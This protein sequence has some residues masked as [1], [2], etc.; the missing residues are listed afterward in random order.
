MAEV[1]RTIE[2][3]LSPH[4]S[5]Y[6]MQINMA[7]SIVH[8]VTGAALYFGTLLLAAWL[9]SAA[10]GAEAFGFVNQLL[11]HPLGLLILLGYTWAVIHHMLGGVRHLIW[12]T[13]RAFDLGSVDALSWFTIIASLSATVAVWAAGLS[14][15]GLS[16][17]DLF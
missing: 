11:G 12:D 14:A 16:L 5:V 7:M 8:R 2:R 4:L 3:P 17:Q 6:R 15:R 1:K 10:L 13:G 9:I